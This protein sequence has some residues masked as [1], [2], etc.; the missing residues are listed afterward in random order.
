M[1][2]FQKKSKAVKRWHSRAMLIDL[3]KTKVTIIYSGEPEDYNWDS[4]LALNFSRKRKRKEN[5][6]FQSPATKAG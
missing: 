6:D 4:G 5:K 2:F 3:R 1:K